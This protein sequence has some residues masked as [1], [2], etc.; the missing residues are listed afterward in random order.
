[1]GKAAAAEFAPHC[2]PARADQYPGKHLAVEASFQAAGAAADQNGRF[3]FCQVCKVFRIA[4]HQ[5]RL[6]RQPRDSQSIGT[7]VEQV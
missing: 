1:M 7:N 6:A 2:R 3:D 5:R 4:N